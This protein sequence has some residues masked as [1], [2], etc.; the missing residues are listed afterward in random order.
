MHF[1]VV[2]P[3]LSA[4]TGLTVA[5]SN[6]NP[7]NI[8]AVPIEQRGID[9]MRCQKQERMLRKPIDA[10]CTTQKESC[11]LLCLQ[12]PGN[13]A[14][15]QSNDCDAD[16]LS[17]TCVCEG[18]QTPNASEYSQTVPYFECTTANQQCVDAC[19]TGNNPCFSNCRDGHPCGAQDPPKLNTTN[20]T[21][22]MSQTATGSSSATASD[23]SAETSFATLGPDGSQS[24]GGAGAGTNA[25]GES[26]GTSLFDF[27]KCYGMF[28]VLGSVFAGFALIL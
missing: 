28:I 7:F 18:G 9:L 2:L 22:T 1:A 19:P 13:D 26:A 20:T 25:S 15:T 4:L 27:G 11:P 16:T 17:Y 5:Q 12:Y 23:G 6:P 21:S 14:S 10:W 3:L 8:T 24:T